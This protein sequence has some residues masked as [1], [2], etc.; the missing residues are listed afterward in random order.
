MG[1][2]LEDHQCVLRELG[3]IVLGDQLM[4]AQRHEG[5]V[6]MA[7]H[8]ELTERFHTYARKNYA[9]AD[10]FIEHVTAQR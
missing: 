10:G 8:P 7:E 6:F 2:A 1:A 5:I 4:S 3:T 9:A